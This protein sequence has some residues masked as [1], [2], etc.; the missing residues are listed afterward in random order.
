MAI[1]VTVIKEVDTI[2]KEVDNIDKEVDNIDKEVNTIT[3]EVTMESKQD[4]QSKQNFASWDI[5]SDA[6]AL[7]CDDGQK[8]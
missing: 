1:V 5:T 3:K 2:T 7:L 4:V 8:F 6:Q